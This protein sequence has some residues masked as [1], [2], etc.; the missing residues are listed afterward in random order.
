MVKLGLVT[1]PLMVS[2]AVL[3]AAAV[4]ALITRLTE[5]GEPAL[6]CTALDGEKLQVAPAG[7][8]GQ[9]RVTDPWNDPAAVT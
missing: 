9:E 8:P 5:A 1:A 6:G 7:S 2:P 4:P 3:P